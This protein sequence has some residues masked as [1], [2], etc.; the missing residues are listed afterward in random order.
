MAVGRDRGFFLCLG[1][2]NVWQF[3]GAVWSE[4]KDSIE[5]MNN[6]LVYADLVDEIQSN[7][8]K[9]SIS[10]GFHIIDAL[11]LGNSG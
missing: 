4:V 2:Q 3:G 6:T 5:L 9:Q 7:G 1:G 8:A 10:T 11:V